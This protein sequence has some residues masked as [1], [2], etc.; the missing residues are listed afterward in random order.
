MQGDTKTLYRSHWLRWDTMTYLCLCFNLF[1]LITYLSVFIRLS[2]WKW[3]LETLRD[4]ILD[5]VSRLAGI[6]WRLV[7]GT[8]AQKNIVSWK[9]MHTAGNS[10]VLIFFLLTI[11]KIMEMNYDKGADRL[12]WVCHS[13]KL[14]FKNRFIVQIKRAH[15]NITCDEKQ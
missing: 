5:V 9:Y 11:N 15:L 14:K 10:Q 12:Y 8:D 13:S 4:L 1:L 2:L 7:Y 3:F 6:L